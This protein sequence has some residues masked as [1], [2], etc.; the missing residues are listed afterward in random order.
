[1]LWMIVCGLSM[2]ARL[3]SSSPLQRFERDLR[4]RLASSP[5]MADDF[6]LLGREDSGGRGRWATSLD[7]PRRPTPSSALGTVHLEAPRGRSSS[8]WAESSF[9]G[10]S[11][12]SGSPDS[13]EPEQEAE[14]KHFSHFCRL[15]PSQGVQPLWESTEP[16]HLSPRRMSRRRR[17]PP[18]LGA[19]SRHLPSVGS[20]PTTRESTLSVR[21]TAS[22]VGSEANKAGS[23][24][25]GTPDTTFW[26]EVGERA[27]LPNAL[28]VTDSVRVAHLEATRA[29]TASEQSRRPSSGARAARHWASSA[30]SPLERR[31]TKSWWVH[32]GKDRTGKAGADHVP[33]E[34]DGD[35]SRLFSGYNGAAPIAAGV[36]M[37]AGGFPASTGA[38]GPLRKPRSRRKSKPIEGVLSGGPAD[39]GDPQLLSEWRNTGGS[40]MQPE[41]LRA[42]TP[43]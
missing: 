20:R 35:T 26:P 15:K 42:W 6:R 4:F 9:A 18:S 3:T 1:V 14:L 31:G 39:A 25:A 41:G 17:S 37:G 43:E 33:G 22:Q 5:D 30:P 36:E 12:R 2:G 21:T 28:A 32:L 11:P 7:G 16:A 38:S 8:P 19:R 13:L 24:R 40:T 29:R 10:S 34:L 27:A 23:T